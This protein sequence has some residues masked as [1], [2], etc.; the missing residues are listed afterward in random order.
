M[1]LVAY[2][3]SPCL[4]HCQS[5]EQEQQ[6]NLGSFLRYCL[7]T[8]LS[9]ETNVIS[10]IFLHARLFFLRALL[11][12]TFC[13]IWIFLPCTRVIAAARNVYACVDVCTVR[14]GRGRPGTLVLLY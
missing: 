5:E 8:K 13:S 4:R 3:F 7:L 6:A 2:L 12:M 11:F 14:A 1:Q 9:F 10:F